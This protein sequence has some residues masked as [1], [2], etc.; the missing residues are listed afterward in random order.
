[1]NCFD[2]SEYR[3]FSLGQHVRFKDKYLKDRPDIA[4]CF[5]GRIGTVS[6]YR[7]G[8]AEPIVDFPKHGRFKA[9]KLFEVSNNA[10]EKA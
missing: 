5:A 7:L 10:L 9:K 1:M 8:A 2:R 4:K 6:G 3:I